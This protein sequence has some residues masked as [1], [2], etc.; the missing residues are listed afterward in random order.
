[1]TLKAVGDSK[2]DEA[3]FVFG[4]IRVEILYGVLILEYAFRL[5]E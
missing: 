4:M 2:K 1:M 5:L 3:I